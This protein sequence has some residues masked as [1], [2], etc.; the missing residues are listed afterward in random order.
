VIDSIRDG[1]GQSA[2]VALDD[3]VQ[4]HAGHFKQGRQADDITIMFL[5]RI[6][7]PA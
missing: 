4:D 3:L 7:A 6:A 2:S 1:F 5:H